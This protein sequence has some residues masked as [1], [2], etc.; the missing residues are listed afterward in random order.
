MQDLL[1]VELSNISQ[2]L[3]TNKLSLNVKKTHYMVITRKGV[4][5]N[6]IV[7]KINDQVISEVHKT[8]FLGVIIDNKMSQI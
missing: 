3:V 8:K 7:V 5:K 6:S 2:W 1:N 4:A